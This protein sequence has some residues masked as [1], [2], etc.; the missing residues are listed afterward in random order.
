[1]TARKRTLLIEV[2]CGD[3]EC[4][5]CEIRDGS[6]W[7]HWLGWHST[8]KRPPEC[9]AAEQPKSPAVWA[10]VRDAAGKVVSGQH[11]HPIFGLVRRDD[12]QRWMFDPPGGGDAQGPFPTKKRAQLRAEKHSE[13]TS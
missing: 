5:P 9:L 2:E 11:E 10:P 7:C 3:K 8:G 6:G 13:G 1:M 12:R 4:G